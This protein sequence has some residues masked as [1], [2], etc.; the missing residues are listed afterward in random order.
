L[1]EKEEKHHRHRHSSK[2]EKSS[3]SGIKDVHSSSRK[4]EKDGDSII[5]VPVEQLPSREREWVSDRSGDPLIEQ[6][7]SLHKGDV[8]KYLRIGYGHVLG[9]QQGLKINRAESDDRKL[10]LDLPDRYD[11][12]A[13]S[14]LVTQGKTIA[15]NPRTVKAVESEEILVDEPAFIPFRLSRKRKRDFKGGIHEFID[16]NE[17]DTQDSDE[18]S[19]LSETDELEDEHDATIRK[20]NAELIA[21]TKREPQNLRNWLD[22][23]QHQDQ[24]ILLGRQKDLFLL[25]SSGKRSLSE[26]KVSVYKQAL[27]R[28]LG[29]SETQEVLWLGML[30]EGENV[31]EAKVQ[32]RYWGEALVALPQSFRVRI[33]YFD[34]FQTNAALFRAGEWLSSRSFM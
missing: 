15:K 5:A 24:L 29:I 11:F 32:E 19:A 2:S 28:T 26:I 18:G 27:S 10:V 8:P 16:D 34:Y 1:P 12:P 31:W 25:G 6:Y 33:K 17:E 30:E 3:R 7:L 14:V 9:T 23:V 21:S 4:S 20:R 13:K 22:L